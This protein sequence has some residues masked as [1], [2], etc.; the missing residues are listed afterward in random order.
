MQ[1]A[2]AFRLDLRPTLNFT[3]RAEYPL[4]ESG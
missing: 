4:M 1:N 3:K 2:P